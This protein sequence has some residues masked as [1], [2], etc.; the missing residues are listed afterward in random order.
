MTS[1]IDFVEVH[2][3]KK[4]VVTCENENNETPKKHHNNAVEK[5]FKGRN[6]KATRRA[7]DTTVTAKGDR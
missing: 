4:I 2:S 1:Y 6:F 3:E 5:Y 7:S